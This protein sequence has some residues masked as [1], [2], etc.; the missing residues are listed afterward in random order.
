M[1]TKTYVVMANDFPDSVFSSEKKAEAYCD[2]QRNNDKP[3][4]VYSPRVYWR[5]HEFI[6]DEKEVK[7]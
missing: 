4:S 5:I 1:K 3:K 2:N 7:K 6:I